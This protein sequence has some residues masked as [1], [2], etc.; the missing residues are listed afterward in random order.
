M[1]KT[2]LVIGIDCGVNTGVATWNIGSQEFLLIKTMPIHRALDYVKD[3][4]ASHVIRLRV[5]DARQVKFNTNPAK[6]QGAGSVKRDAKIW[7]D[8]CEDLGIEVQFIRP[9]KALTK[10]SADAFKKYTG[11]AGSTNNHNRDAGLLAFGFKN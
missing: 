8:F 9:S 6:A 2:E 10:W 1:S 4:H 11:W 5:E 3:R 7:Q